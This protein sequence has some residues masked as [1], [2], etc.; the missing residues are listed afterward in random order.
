M[1]H[2]LLTKVVFNDLKVSSLYNTSHKKCKELVP[3]KLQFKMDKNPKLLR[4]IDIV[5]TVEQG[6]LACL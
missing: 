6:V 2:A 4:I 5:S 3:T 1:A